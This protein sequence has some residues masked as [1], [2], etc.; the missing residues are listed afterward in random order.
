MR[1]IKSLRVVF[2]PAGKFDPFGSIHQVTESGLSQ[3]LFQS[4]QRSLLG[5]G[6]LS[7]AGLSQ[8]M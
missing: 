4:G 3:E 7:A 6:F 1:G 5:Q 8:W 2:P